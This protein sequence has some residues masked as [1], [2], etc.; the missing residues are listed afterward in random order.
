[1]VTIFL[2]FVTCF[3][4]LIFIVWVS[5]FLFYA[6]NMVKWTNWIWNGCT[7]DDHSV[8]MIVSCLSF[9]GTWCRCDRKIIAL[10]AL[11]IKKQ[12]DKFKFCCGLIFLAL[13]ARKWSRQTDA[14]SAACGKLCSEWWANLEPLGYRPYPSFT[15]EHN[16]LSVC[17][18]WL[19]IENNRCIIIIIIIIII[20]T[21]S[22]FQ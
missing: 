20:V 9:V 8:W 2:D 17:A 1:M 13:Q 7:K 18:K 22:Y 6:A 19:R 5:Y 11:V 10:V 15:E 3:T 4:L 16:I 21:S 12:C 14:R